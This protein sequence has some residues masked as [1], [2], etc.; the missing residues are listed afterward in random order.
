MQTAANLFYFASSHT[1][2]TSSHV[3]PAFNRVWSMYSFILGSAVESSDS[4]L[5][6]DGLEGDWFGEDGPEL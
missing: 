2:L 6:T 3:V 1:F 4:Y 5:E